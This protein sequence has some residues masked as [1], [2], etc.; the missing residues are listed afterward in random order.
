[1]LVWWFFFIYIHF[2]LKF[3]FTLWN[4]SIWLFKTNWASFAGYTVKSILKEAH[5]DNFFFFDL[6]P[7]PLI[8]RCFFIVWIILQIR[9]MLQF[10]G[11]TDHALWWTDPNSA[12]QSSSSGK[13]FCFHIFPHGYSLWFCISTTVQWIQLQINSLSKLLESLD[14]FLNP[15]SHFLWSVVQFIQPKCSPRV[16]SDPSILFAEF[17]RVCISAGWM[18]LMDAGMSKM[19]HSFST[20]SLSKLL[21]TPR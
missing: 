15:E 4:W 16:R 20:K 11:C 17:M 5:P 3:E 2:T 21:Q 7:N 19:K 6:S 8:Y 13:L 1:M 12:R 14:P 18:N 10:I 9:G